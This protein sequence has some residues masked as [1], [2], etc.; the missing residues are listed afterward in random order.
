[1]HMRAFLREGPIMIK[2]KRHTMNA[3]DPS[4]RIIDHVVAG[5]KAWVRAD[6]QRDDWFFR[7]SSECLAELNAIIAELRRDVRSVEQIDPARF[8][9]PRWSIG[10]RWKQSVLTRRKR[11][12]GY[13]R[14]C[15]R[16]PF[17]KS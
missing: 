17:S 9:I 4:Q 8:Q 7:L 13:C 2:T 1:M 6:I 14:R 11:C 3:T 16:V 5:K 10:C 12:T 15:W